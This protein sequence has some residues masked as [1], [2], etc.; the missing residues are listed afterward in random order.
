MTQIARPGQGYRYQPGLPMSD[1]RVPV[2]GVLA[3]RGTPSRSNCSHAPLPLRLSLRP[4]SRPGHVPCPQAHRAFLR[5]RTLRI[6]SKPPTDADLCDGLTC[7]QSGGC[8]VIIDA[9]AI[10][11]PWMIVS[12]RASAFR[13]SFR[14]SGDGYKRAQ[15]GRGG[16]SPPYP[17][18]QRVTIFDNGALPTKTARRADCIQELWS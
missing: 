6:F 12:K 10:R 14:D 13:N 4:D 1:S 18:R 16:L 2:S 7:A 17:V 8:I 11:K 9:P 3:G 15:P 5:D